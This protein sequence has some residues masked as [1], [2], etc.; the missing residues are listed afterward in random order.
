MR[1]LSRFFAP[2]LIATLL[3][4]GCA[5]PPPDSAA[6][7]GAPGTEDARAA[8]PPARTRPAPPMS[9]PLPPQQVPDIRP[10]GAA[11]PSDS[12]TLAAL[13]RSCRTSADCAVK[14]VGSCCGYKPA[15]LNTNAKPDPGAVKAQ[16]AQQGMVSTCGFEEI[17]S[18]ACVQGRCES[19][20]A[21]AAI[22]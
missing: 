3:G 9:D 17:Q 10:T 16:C 1:V 20:D 8:T 19:A 18:C 21:G 14:D 2:L 12:P 22:R 5:A 13:D 15:C 11:A 4:A 6:L 7:A